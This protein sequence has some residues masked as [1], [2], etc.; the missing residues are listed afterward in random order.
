ME[1]LELLDLDLGLSVA[2]AFEVIVLT[3]SQQTVLPVATNANNISLGGYIWISNKILYCL[4]R[5]GKLCNQMD[6]KLFLTTRFSSL[7]HSERYLNLE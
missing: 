3:V 5:T 6:N 7:L 1:R 4:I 2:F